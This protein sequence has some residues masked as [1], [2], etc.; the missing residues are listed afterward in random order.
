MSPASSAKRLVNL[1]RPQNVNLYSA[2][3]RNMEQLGDAALRIAD[4]IHSLMRDGILASTGR[5]QQVRH[6][7]A[8]VSSIAASAVRSG[9]ITAG[10]K[11]C[12]RGG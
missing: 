1:S 4:H 2:V 6:R 8:P 10:R 7:P 5:P 9:R 3:D 12:G 11:G